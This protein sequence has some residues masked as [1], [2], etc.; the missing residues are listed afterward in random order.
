MNPDII[1]V[2]NLVFTCKLSSRLNLRDVTT[3]SRGKC[4]YNPKKFA[5]AIQRYSDPKIA[6]LMFSPG[7]FVCTGSKKDDQ[8]IFIVDDVVSGLKENGYDSIYIERF[9]IQN[10]VC[11]ALLGVPID[12]D[13]LAAERS[14]ECNYEPD[15]F[16]GVVMRYEPIKPV[17]VLVFKSGKMV[18]TGAKSETEA[19]SHF[20]TLYEII[21]KYIRPTIYVQDNIFG[22]RINVIN[23]LVKEE[24]FENPIK[25]EIIKNEII[26]NEII[27]VKQEFIEPEYEYPSITKKIRTENIEDEQI[28]NKRPSIVERKY[29]VT[30]PIKRPTQIQKPQ[31]N[32]NQC[33]YCH[34]YCLRKYGPDDIAYENICC[35]CLHSEDTIHEANEANKLCDWCKS[36]Y[37]FRFGDIFYSK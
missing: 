18:L 22:Q 10:V 19:R 8:A 16:P 32:E 27:E 20:N 1:K 30:T 25:S 2:E 4:S 6:V 33:I 17:T 23:N 34:K 21:K 7:K 29:M 26:K 9:D 12:C 3:K 36:T 5:A 13:L 35:I 28:T 14:G 31:T 11:R 15:L 24:I 37:K